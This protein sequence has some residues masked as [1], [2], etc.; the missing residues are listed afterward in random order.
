MRATKLL[1]ITAAAWL[2]SAG[3]LAAQT[4]TSPGGTA[5]QTG[6]K[7]PPAPDPKLSFDREVFSYSGE[8]RKDPFAPLVG[9]DAIGPLFEDLSLHG[10][11]FSSDPKLS[12]VLIYDGAKRPYRLHVGDVIGNARLASVTRTQ[13]KFLVQ[14]YGLIREEAMNL[15]PRKTLAEL[16]TQKQREEGETLQKLFQQEL[17]KA[18]KGQ[19]DSVKPPPRISK[20]SLLKITPQRGRTNN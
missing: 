1:L 12:V 18:L 7:T 3:A 6:P 11:L 16:Q 17:L 2:A 13:V 4:P 20:D 15:A 10:I 8:G 9:T 19:P 5:G 14:S